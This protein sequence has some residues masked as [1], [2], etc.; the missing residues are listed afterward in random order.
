[1][2]SRTKN[3][4]ISVLMPVFN[5]EDFIR[6]AVDSI[7][8]Q[9]FKDF[10]LLVIDDGST[11]NTW[12]IINS[13]SDTR[14][15]KL[16]NPKNKGIVCSLN[17]ALKLARGKY[18]ARMDS[19]DISVAD[20][21]EKQYK[22]MEN[23]PEIDVCGS[24]VRYFTRVPG[25]RRTYGTKLK[26]EAIKASFL[27]EN[28][29]QHP[30]VVCRKKIFKNK[31][32]SHGYP[33]AED[34]ALWVTLADTSSFAI[35][36]EILLNYRLHKN[37]IGQREN[38]VQSDSVKRVHKKLLKKTGV[39]ASP[40]E[41]AIHEKLCSGQYEPT[42]DFVEEAHM[43]LIKIRTANLK[44]RVFDPKTLD[45]ILAA[46]WLS[47]CLMTGSLRR[48]VWNRYWQ[49]PFAKKNIGD[50]GMIRQ[51]WLESTFFPTLRPYVVKMKSS[52]LVKR[53]LL[54]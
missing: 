44:S 27:F 6:G 52:P 20:R 18:I 19:D 7:L 50:G 47:T 12:K 34:Y 46:R 42:R 11:D 40:K 43:W 10:E 2:N 37:Q 35:Y 54:G 33:H 24:W 28:V 17:K 16:K 31:S 26:P 38:I 14:L 23:H 45:T 13:F 32:Y 41:F 29:I 5:S 39:R 1:M 25:I 51:L 30:T 4:A 9:T 49:S 3:P 48:W 15:V 21:L 22:F 36:P 53:L 8:N